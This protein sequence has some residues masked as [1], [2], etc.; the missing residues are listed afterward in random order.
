MIVLT[1]TFVIGALVAVL[2][3]VLAIAG[4]QTRLE[5]EAARQLPPSSRKAA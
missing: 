1:M 3:G 2:G 4:E 5:E